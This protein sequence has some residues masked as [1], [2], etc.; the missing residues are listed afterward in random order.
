MS[1]PLAVTLPLMPRVTIQVGGPEP[2]VRPPFPDNPWQSLPHGAP[3]L[4]QLRTDACPA[5]RRHAAREGRSVPAGI[6]TPRC[7]GEGQPRA[8]GSAAPLATCPIEGKDTPVRRT[9][10]TLS[11]VLG[12]LLIIGGV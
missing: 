11:I 6:V 9:A 3:S 10:A 2:S 5:S 12:S 1:K 7:P 8:S 4:V